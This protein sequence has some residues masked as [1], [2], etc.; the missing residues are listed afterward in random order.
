MH[1]MFRL[2]AHRPLFHHA[3]HI[4]AARIRL[5]SEAH[6]TFLDPTI[7]SGLRQRELDIAIGGPSIASVIVEPEV[8]SKL[9]GKQFA[10]GEKAAVPLTFFHKTKHFAKGE[11]TS[12]C[13]RLLCP[14]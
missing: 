4:N 11:F 14:F 13:T 12:P 2:S 6:A 5:F 3:R 1:T 9:V 10:E 7:T 8:A